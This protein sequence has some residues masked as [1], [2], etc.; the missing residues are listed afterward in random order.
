MDP[1]IFE[2]I[3]ESLI[4]KAAIKTKGAAGPSGLDSDGWRR[5]LISK[6]YG[7]IGKDLR[8]AIAEMAKNLCTHKVEITNGKTSLEAYTASKLIPLDKNPGVRPI[9]I[10]EVLRRIIGKA[11]ISTIKPEIMKSAGSLQLCAGQEAGCEAATHA[12]NQIFLEEETDALLLVDA[13]NA[14]NSINRKVMLHNIQHLCPAM[15]TYAYNSYCTSAR[16][17]VQG[18]K[19]ITSSEGTTQ[20]DSFAMPM[21]AIGVTPL[22]NNIKNETNTKIKH[23]AFADDLAGA[24]CLVELKHWWDNI[25]KYGPLLGY[26]PKASKSWLIVKPTMLEQAQHFFL[27]HRCKYYFRRT[28]LFGWIYRK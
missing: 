8:T 6:N 25:E 27:G 11:I 21:Y 2:D 23:A 3:D 16:L 19:E 7:V 10:G 18:G 12:M 1:V 26:Y 5:L 17:F 13:S 24:G 14:F 9:G 22:L 15:A 28:I 4:A 20:G